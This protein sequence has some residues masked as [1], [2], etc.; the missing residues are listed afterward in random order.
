MSD[1]LESKRSLDEFEASFQSTQL[2]KHFWNKQ[3]VDHQN[4]GAKRLTKQSLCE[5][6]H[7]EHIMA[8]NNTKLAEVQK[9]RGRR[10]FR[11]GCES[12]VEHRS[13]SMQP[14]LGGTATSVQT[15]AGAGDK[16]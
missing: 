3:N 10:Q 14:V 7:H 12:K 15:I 1:D 8:H 13:F 4:H 6:T 11:K 16:V 2:E 9:M 5:S